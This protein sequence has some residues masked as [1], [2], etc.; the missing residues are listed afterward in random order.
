MKKKVEDAYNP[1][2][3]GRKERIVVGLSGGYD[4][5]VAAYLLKIQ[6][7]E[8]FAVTVA[9]GWDQFGGNKNE[10]LSCYL[11]DSKLNTIRE[12]CQS[13]SIPHF[14]VK[15]MTEFQENVIEKWMGAKALGTLN[16]ACW[17]CHDLRMKILHQ[18][19][20]DLDA[21]WFAT[22]HYAK[23]FHHEGHATSYVHTS[24]DEDNDQSS[25]LSRLP[26]EILATLKLPLSDL[27]KKEVVKLAENFGL[28]LSE[29]ALKMH[30]CFPT[31][32]DTIDYLSKRI[33]PRFAKE[34]ELYSF[35][36][37]ENFGEHSGVTHYDYGQAVD[38]QSRG[39]KEKLFVARFN[40]KDRRIYLR[41]ADFFKRKEI[42]LM[43]CQI[44]EETPWNEPMRG[45]VKLSDDEYVECWIYPKSLRSAH[46]EWEGSF[47]VNEGEI[48]TVLRKKGK[49][50]KIYLT[51]V[52]KY[53][54]RK[55]AEET[56]GEESEK[57]DHSR[58]F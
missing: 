1:D 23:L 12:F 4:S 32:K 40:N 36:G 20:I 16:T 19:M 25:C 58:D 30:E 34:G 2:K 50:S 7:Y 28:N 5:F 41:P 31:N 43:N 13:L 14:V 52:A 57:V 48:L 51:G 27:H 47:K 22:G 55:E 37:D 56:E 53:I 18:K 21:K 11:D 38:V 54:T 6:K 15:A 17:A 42:F 46:L 9:I 24:N 3:S 29:K 35:N 10:T 44:S 26:A 33:P 8:V 39:K 49:N 45:V